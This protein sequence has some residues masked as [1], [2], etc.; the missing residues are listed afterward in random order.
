VNQPLKHPHASHTTTSAARGGQIAFIQ[1]CWH[2]DIVDQCR[3]AFEAELQRL[4]RP[5]TLIDF[6][7]VPGVFEIPLQSKLLA[8]TGRYAAIV[9][10]GLVVDGGIYRHEFVS[11][12]VISGLMRVQL[13]T[14]VPV[15][16]AVLTPQHFHEHEDHKRFFREHFVVKGTEAAKACSATISNIE[17]ARKLAA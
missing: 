15:I 2:K 14:D 17:A 6:F 7:E 11:E 3:I 1:S 9:A 13:D 5:R 8:R 4:G 10:T 12:A 16:S